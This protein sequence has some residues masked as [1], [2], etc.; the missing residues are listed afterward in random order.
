MPDEIFI[1]NLK[2]VEKFFGKIADINND[3]VLKKSEKCDEISVFYASLEIYKQQYSASASIFPTPQ[4]AECDAIFVPELPLKDMLVTRKK[5][6]DVQEPQMQ[7]HEFST[8]LGKKWRKIF[9]NSTL[10]DTFFQKLCDV[11][12]TLK[13]KVPDS[14]WNKAKYSSPE[15]QALDEVIAIFAGEARLNPRTV[16]KVKGKS[17]FYGLF[18]ISQQGLTSAKHWAK[19]HPEIPG[20]KNIKQNMTLSAFRN[21]KGEEQLDYLVAYIGA[22]RD[23]SNISQDEELSPAKLWS[24]IKLP[25]LDE[26]NPAKKARRER[27][28]A[29]KQ[30]SIDNVFKNNKIPL[31]IV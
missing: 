12:T 11:M 28:I 20:M 5:E 19:E 27:T 8:K 18:Q 14:E 22:S 16:G 29:Q 30:D 26:N 17:M 10:T 2:G 4:I 13:I 15:E 25:N 1:N 6:I 21:L 9:V 24:M 3:G 7:M 31:G 23:A